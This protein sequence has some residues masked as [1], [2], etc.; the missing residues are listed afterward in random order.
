MARKL[1]KEYE[2]WGP[3]INMDKTQYLYVGETDL[4]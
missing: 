3:Q 1:K 4:D 2:K